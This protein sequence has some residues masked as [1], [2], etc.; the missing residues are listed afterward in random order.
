[1]DSDLDRYSI[2]D[3]I[4]PLPGR[5]VSLPGGPLGERYRQFLVADGLDPDNF[6]R[7]QKYVHPVFC[8]RIAKVGHAGNT[9]WA[10]HTARYCISPKSFRGPY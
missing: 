2:F 4:M 7:K 6:T 8:K 5:D 10:D 3:V 1:M 9:V